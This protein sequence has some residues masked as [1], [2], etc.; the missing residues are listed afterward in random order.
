MVMEVVYELT[1]FNPVGVNDKKT[2]II[3][4]DT[5]RGVK[6]YIQSLRYRY[7]RK[8]PYIPNYVISKTGEVY[9][10]MEP[11]MYSRFLENETLDKKSIIISL[12]NF[13]CLKKN[14]LQDTYVNW[15]GDIY[16]QKAFERKWRDC[17]F[18]DNY[19]ENQ[20]QSLGN[21]IKELCEQF[22][23]PKISIG[24]N[25][26]QEGVENFKGIASRSNYDADF[27]DVN[28]AFDFKRL[29]KILNDVK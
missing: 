1:D 6:N 22:D 24:H 29:E 20:I 12:E 28:P 5:K 9:K 4:T 2:Q 18:W 27:K 14:P 23:I 7:N 15:I 16:K 8:N 25:V 21:L 11:N 3:L 26:R 13:G 19:E 17:F 10:I